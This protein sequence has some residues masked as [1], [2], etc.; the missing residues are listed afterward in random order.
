[1]LEP[2]ASSSSH[3]SAA[4]AAP[5]AAPTVVTPADRRSKW[6]L[7]AI[8]IGGVFATLLILAVGFSARRGRPGV[9]APK[10][11]APVIVP[12]AR[13]E[14]AWV[15]S[16]I[17]RR[18]NLPTQVFMDATDVYFTT[19]EPDDRPH[20]CV[21]NKVSRL[22]GP[23]ELVAQQPYY[24][25]IEADSKHIYWD[26]LRKL[27]VIPKTGGP[28]RRIESP[29]MT[30]HSMAVDEERLY[31]AASDDAQPR[32][33]QRIVA[34]AKTG[35]APT[36][37]AEGLDHVTAVRATRDHVYWSTRIPDGT[38]RGSIFRVAKSGGAPEAVVADSG[39]VWFMLLDDTHVYFIG[40]E[41]GGGPLGT[42]GA[43]SALYR[44]SLAGGQ[45]VRL[46][47]F[48]AKPP[49]MGLAVEGDFVFWLVDSTDKTKMDG[50]LHALPKSGGAP[51]AIAAHQAS[52]RDV[53]GFGGALAWV[54]FGTCA[55]RECESDYKGDGEVHLA[56]MVR[57]AAESW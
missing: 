20:G 30:S 6:P 23:T 17:S 14:P 53:V 19:F 24:G 34:L 9:A 13:A 38:G 48:P 11:R 10:E 54:T 36:V 46:I 12:P 55:S 32:D 27:L 56:T 15:A 57:R 29:Y 40:K 7:L 50:S 43:A 22:G 21:L 37:L 16:T 42:G 51:R 28:I 2:P 1:M 41:A 4:P 33:H 8:V 39:A 25:T 44:V 49:V 5:P 35:G 52:S 47:A 18:Q 31:F 26:S 45:P 3:V